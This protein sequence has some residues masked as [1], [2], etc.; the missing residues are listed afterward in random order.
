MDQHQADKTS[1]GIIRPQKVLDLEIFPAGREWKPEWADLYSQMRLFGDPP[2][3]LAKLP[4]TW[5]Y[6]F[7]CADN[8]KPHRAMIED[9]ELGVLF[10]KLLEGHDERTAAEKV[11]R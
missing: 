3:P 8:P 4:F 7:E 11:L 9:W 5:K 10:L 1:L 6:V 2:K